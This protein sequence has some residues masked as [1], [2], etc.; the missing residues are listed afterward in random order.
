[1]KMVCRAAGLT[2]PNRKAMRLVC[3]VAL[4]LATLSGTQRPD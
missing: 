2:T 4:F 1:M 3:P